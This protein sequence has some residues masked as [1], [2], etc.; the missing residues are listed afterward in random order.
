LTT[1]STG[2]NKNG[3]PCS[4]NGYDANGTLQCQLNSFNKG[5]SNLNRRFDTRHGIL[6]T[7]PVEEPPN[8][9][10]TK[11]DDHEETSAITIV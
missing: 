6:L 9:V 7:W 11:K 5:S 2:K 3:D 4:Y 10:Y 8:K 1:F